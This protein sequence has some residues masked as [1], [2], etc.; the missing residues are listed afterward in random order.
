MNDYRQLFE[1]APIGIINVSLEGK[2]LL[3]NERAALS[4]GYDSPEAFLAEVHSMLDLWVNLE[5]R[6]RAAEIMLETG[7]LRDFEVPMRR[8]DGRRVVLS[9]SANP[10]KDADGTVIG[11]QVSGIEITDRVDAERRLD[12]AQAQASIGFWSFRLD[13]QEFTR[14]DET[15]RIFG[16]DPSGAPTDLTELV[17]LI[18]PEDLN[19]VGMQLMSFGR[20]A[21]DSFELEFRITTRD[22]EAKWLIVRG[23]VDEDGVVL[24]GSVQ[25]VTKQ[26]LVEARLKELNELKTEFV[27]VVAHDLRSPLAVASGYTTFLREQ[28][29]TFGD[30]E[31]RKFLDTVQ[32]SLDRLGSLVSSVL[33]VTRLESGTATAEAISF[34]LAELVRSVVN[35]IATTAPSRAC[36]VAV[37]GPLPLV[38]A[39]PEAVERVVTN[40]VSNALKYSDPDS[41]IDVAV[42][43][44]SRGMRV[45][46]RDR[47]P[48][49]APADQAKL[50]QRFSRLTSSDGP[51]TDGTGLGLFICRSLVESWGGSIWVESAVGRGS[52]F[53]F[54]VPAESESAAVQRAV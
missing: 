45:T 31:R 1:N 4:F 32:R 29:D 27:G 40:L 38:V 3:V 51:R 5:D 11:L 8:R 42:E 39:D 44:S 18:H 54:T 6:D 48:G 22:G 41:P 20:A 43:R 14:S 49:I 50:F 23:L 53:S 52:A 19:D 26:K 35:E 9:L 10:W 16:L 25:D 33:E 37:A 15:V 30:S 17:P 46:V 12:E 34:D 24:S 2:P 28:W 36:S 47:G 7:V 21:N 13:T